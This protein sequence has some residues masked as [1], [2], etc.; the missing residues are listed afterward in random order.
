METKQVIVLRHKYPD[1]KGG[2]RKIRTGKLV[3]QGSH[4]A[5]AF[6]GRKLQLAINKGLIE[7]KRGRII[8]REMELTQAEFDWFADSFAK[9]VAKAEDE[10]QLLAIYE[11]AKGAGLEAHLITDSGRTEFSEPTRTCVGIGPDLIERI[12]P[13]TKELSLL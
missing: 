6:M 8:V 9:V 2:L 7:F 3:A 1:D 4:A 12:D 10:E 5:V 11:K 13:I